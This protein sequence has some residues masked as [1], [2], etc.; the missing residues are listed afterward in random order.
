MLETTH[1]NTVNNYIDFYKSF[2]Q[3]NVSNLKTFFQNF[4]PPLK[5]QHPLCVSL[6]MEIITRV[7]TIKPDLAEKMYLVSCEEAVEESLA[8]VSHCE[9]QSIESA[10]WSLEKEHSLVAMR[11]V[12]AGREGIILLDPGYHVSRVVTI[13]KDQLYPHTGYFTQ[14]HD[15]NCQREYNYAFHPTSDNFITWTERVTRLDQQT[16]EFSL[17][18]V[19]KPYKTAVDVTVRRNL[20]YNF[21]SLLSRSAKGKVLS[22]IYFPVINAGDAQFT[23]FYD[24]GLNDGSFKLKQKFSVFKDLTKVKFDSCNLID[25]ILI[26]ELSFYRFPITLSTI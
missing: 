21:R 3:S 6:A 1:Y 8:Y 19:Q 9:E 16:Y 12:V 5:R 26:L 11:I 17:I 13:M 22:G 14:S 7:A 18:Y 4:A 23:L 20:V 10:S 24:D 15:N 25:K 2:K